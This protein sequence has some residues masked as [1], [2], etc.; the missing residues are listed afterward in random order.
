M[1]EIPSLYVYFR[2][3]CGYTRFRA[4]CRAIYCWL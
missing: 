2:R 4:I 3:K 1:T